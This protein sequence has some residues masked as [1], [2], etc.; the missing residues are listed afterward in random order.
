MFSTNMKCWTWTNQ[1]Y[2]LVDLSL[3]VRIQDALLD[4]IIFY[5][6]DSAAQII[7]KY[8]ENTQA[9]WTQENNVIVQRQCYNFPILRRYIVIQIKLIE[10]T[11]RSKLSN[12]DNTAFISMNIEKQKH[13]LHLTKK[14]QQRK[15]HRK[16]HLCH[17][18]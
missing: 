4:P 1:D 12:K 5:M 6:K 14:P 13:H 10:T 18:L 9:K 11:D 15:W 16:Q 2:I 3:D 8:F 17:F 7:R